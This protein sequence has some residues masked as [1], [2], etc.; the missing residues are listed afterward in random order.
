MP[1]LGD[2]V[3]SIDGAWMVRPPT[4]CAHGHRLRPGRMLVGSWFIR[5]LKFAGVASVYS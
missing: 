5:V 1:A 2:L 4:D 3:R